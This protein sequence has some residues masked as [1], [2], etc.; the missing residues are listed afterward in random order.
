[1]WTVKEVEDRDWTRIAALLGTAMTVRDIAEEIG[2]S[3]SVVHRI[4]QKI[5]QEGAEAALAKVFSSCS[6]NKELRRRDHLERHIHPG[7]EM[8]APRWRVAFARGLGGTG[9]LLGRLGSMGGRTY[10]RLIIR[11]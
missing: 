8:I 6:S 7:A 9:C 3:K 1:V 4:K 2:I 5:E 10:Q 11:R